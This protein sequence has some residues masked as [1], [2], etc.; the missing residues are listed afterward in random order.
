MVD[1]MMPLPLGHCTTC[2]RVRYL[3]E[4]NEDGLSGTCTQ[5][6]REREPKKQLSAL[7]RANLYARL[8]GLPSAYTFAFG[9]NLDRGTMYGAEPV[10]KARL[11]GWQ[12]DI[13]GFCDVQ[14][15]DDPTSYVEGA[16]WR[17][18]QQLLSMLDHREGYP[19]FYDRVVASVALPFDGTRAVVYTMKDPGPLRPASDSYIEMVRRGYRQWGLDEACLDAAIDRAPTWSEIDLYADQEETA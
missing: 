1:Q 5:C 4:V 6:D 14:P 15:A 10:S 3:A 18:D 19:T 9:M 17:L 11:F 16:L 13:R 12:L 8:N 7:Q 2:N